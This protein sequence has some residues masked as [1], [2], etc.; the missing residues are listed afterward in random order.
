MNKQQYSF[1]VG[2]VLT[3]A[4]VCFF[5]MPSLLDY[6]ALIPVILGF[7]SLVSALAFFFQGASSD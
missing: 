6:D 7:V 3:I 2:T 5:L 1:R 4:A